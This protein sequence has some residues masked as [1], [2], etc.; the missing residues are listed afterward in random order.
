[1]PADEPGLTAA[2]TRSSGQRRAALIAT[3]IALPVTVLLAFLFTAGSRQ[4]SKQ[5]DKPLAAVTVAAPPPPSAAIAAGCTKIFEKL[6]VQLGSLAPRKTDSDSGFVAA[7][8]DPAIVIRCGVVRPA[9]FSATNGADLQDVDGVL[10]LPDLQKKQVVY[11]TVDRGS[12]YVE[13]TVPA[14]Q[15]QPLSLLAPAISTVAATC[16]GTDAAGNTSGG[17]PVCDNSK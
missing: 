17:L 2:G 5:A 6:P 9:A 14:A 8:G 13:V 12:V 15:D 7:W 1:M 10:W 3:G 4:S 16:G 11:T